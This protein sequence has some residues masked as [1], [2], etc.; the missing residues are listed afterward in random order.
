MAAYQ[1]LIL[2]TIGATFILIGIGLTYAMT[3]TLN[4]ADLA[5]RLT[6]V[7]SSRTVHT[8][9]AFIVVGLAIKFAL[10]PCI[11][12]CPMPTPMRPRR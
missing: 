5:T 10:Y 9:F 12:G 7:Q 11:S 1:Y 6:E 8:A 4:M 2:G 3:G